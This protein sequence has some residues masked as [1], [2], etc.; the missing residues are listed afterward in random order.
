M[1]PIGIDQEGNV[2]NYVDMQDGC[3]YAEFVHCFPSVCPQVS[4]CPSTASTLV[5]T[6]FSTP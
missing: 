4:L 1:N 5:I 6:M 2:R 3:T